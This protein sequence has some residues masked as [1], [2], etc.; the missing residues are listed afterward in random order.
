M[1]VTLLDELAL[2]TNNMRKGIIQAL[3]EQVML[4][5]KLTWENTGA[6]QL[7][8]TYLSGVPTVPLR[9]INEAP[10]GVSA[11][12]AQMVEPLQIIDTDID[13]D[14]VLVAIKNQVTSIEV[15]QT[16]AVVASIG[17]R[18][19]D[20]FVNGDPAVDAREPLGLK[21]RLRD[22]LRLAG[23]TVNATTNTTELDFSPDG[24]DAAKY[25]CLNRIDEL[26]ATVEDKPSF[27]LV[28]RQFR[29]AFW[30]ALRQ[31]KL[32][33]S[34]KDQYEREVATYRGCPIIDPGYKPAAA[35]TGSADALHADT[36][37][38]IGF[39]AD[40]FTAG[41]DPGVGGGAN[42]YAVGA[43]TVYVA[44]VGSEYLLSL[45][46][47]PMRVKALGETEAAPHYVRTNIRWVISPV[48]PLQKRCAG[49][50]VGVAVT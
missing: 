24:T 49:R 6:L 4:Q 15:A 10:A 18:V 14:P 13:I 7:P 21:V 46:L 43:S 5:D 19:N 39:D 40:I 50:L 9:H 11:S 3:V 23:Q 33:A 34:V 27:M 28:G 17:Y 2:E 32:F 20:L 37:Q 35:I 38:I 16:K 45:Q 12:F 1:A 47:E 36:N 48:A 29:L 30:A 44:R 22:D 41:A 8:V 25:A 42:A 26:F 31:L